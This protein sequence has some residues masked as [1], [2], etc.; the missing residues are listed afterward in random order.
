[1]T[2]TRAHA[3]DWWRRPRAAVLAALHATPEGLSTRQAASRLGH[4][5]PN[6]LRAAPRSS[7]ARRFAA[8]LL[9]PLVLV[10]VAASVISAATG[11]A[12][13]FGFVSIVVIFSVALDVL[14]E[15]RA[16][17]AVL[18]L[19][20]SVALRVRAWRDGREVEL[21]AERL[22]P[23]DCVRLAAGDLVPADA[24]LLEANDFFVN[25]AALTG[26]AY[27]V[28]K[29]VDDGAVEAE[30]LAAAGAVFMG[31]SVVSGSARALVCATGARTQLGQLAGTLAAEPPPTAF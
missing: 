24:R 17:R 4:H 16:Q 9:D 1:M 8:R 10:L 18:A 14:Q 26:E 21:P 30:P 23:G 20:Q 27:P 5:G 29:R 25:Q 28:E 22:V 15:H 12:V 3:P 13:S 6:R 2:Q 11:D 7:L 31:S 19:Q